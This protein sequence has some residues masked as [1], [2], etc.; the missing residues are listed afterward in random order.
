M[1]VFSTLLGDERQTGPRSVLRWS[2]GSLPRFTAG[3]EIESQT[4]F[5]ARSNVLGNYAFAELVQIQSLS[6]FFILILLFAR[7]EN[8]FFSPVAPT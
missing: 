6:V 3:I 2:I 7:L 1:L 4:P 8:H 5:A